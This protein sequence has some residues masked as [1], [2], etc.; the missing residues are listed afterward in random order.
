MLVK[1][2]LSR[3]AVVW[4]DSSL[5]PARGFPACTSQPAGGGDSRPEKAGPPASYLSALWAPVLELT[6]F[7]LRGSWCF[8]LSTASVQ[9]P[10][11]NVTCVGVHVCACAQVCWVCAC[12]RSKNNL[13]FS[14]SV[15]VHFSLSFGKLYWFIIFMC[16]CLWVSVLVRTPGAGVTGDCQPPSVGTGS[17][18]Q[19]LW[20]NNMYS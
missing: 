14:Y 3:C 6:S 5:L 16:V 17:Q 18:A 7:H 20:K 1:V 13:V 10:A 12:V 9:P 4:S 19:V 2:S 8:V 11:P 15:T